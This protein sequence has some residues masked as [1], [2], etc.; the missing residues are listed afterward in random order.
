MSRL[1]VWTGCLSLAVILG[2]TAV[3][4]SSK[5]HSVTL[6]LD[7]AYI[8]LQYARTAVAGH[9]GE[10]FPG[11]GRSAGAGSPGSPSSALAGRAAKPSHVATT[12]RSA[13][14]AADS[15]L[16]VRCVTRRG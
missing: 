15:T 6:P 16:A 13:M 7:D 5:G 9:F 11:E 8:Y 1:L 12:N 10:Y 4:L 14:R 3:T 2:F